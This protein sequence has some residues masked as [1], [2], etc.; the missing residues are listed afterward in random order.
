[1]EAITFA[2]VFALGWVAADLFFAVQRFVRTHKRKEPRPEDEICP[3]CG[4]LCL[5][6]GGFGCID[7]PGLIAISANKDD[8][9]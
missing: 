8:A 9:S 5:G 4:Y 6:R 3:V 2:G 1:M 7:K